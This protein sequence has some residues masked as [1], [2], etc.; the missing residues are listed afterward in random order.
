MKRIASLASAAALVAVLAA[1]PACYGSYSA[2]HAVHHW[3]GQVANNKV[4]RSAVNAALWIL[5][6]YELTLLGDVIIF[7]TVEFITGNPVFSAPP[8]QG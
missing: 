1:Q 7:N 2:F 5:P 6:V 4:A 8:P 3:N